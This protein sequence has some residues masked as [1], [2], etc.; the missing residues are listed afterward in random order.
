MKFKLVKINKIERFNYVGSLYDLTVDEDHSYNIS[1]IIVHNSICSTRTTT[2]FGIPTLTSVMDCA[3][4]K[5]DS[6]LVAD[7]GIEYPGDICKAMVGG[8]DMVMVGKLLAATSLSSG[9]KFNKK[10]KKTFNMK[11]A[12]WVSY[13]GMASASAAKG[14]TSKKSS[15]S[16][17][18]V[19]GFIPYTGETDEVVETVIANLRSSMAY[20][21]GCRDWDNF[22]KKVKLAQL[23]MQGW[24]ESSTRVTASI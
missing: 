11:K 5:G 3:K 22:K 20:Y 1:G 9:D 14:L 4:V 24:A 21:A 19:D 8:A 6:Y 2:G 23:T 15:V 18:G 13:R 16:V 17:E 7:G 12:R 10:G